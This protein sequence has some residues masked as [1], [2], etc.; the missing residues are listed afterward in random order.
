LAQEL[1]TEVAMALN[2]P[3]ARLH[4]ILTLCKK[5]EKESGGRPM[6]MGWRKVF[7]L[8]EGVRDFTVMQR[9]GR[10]HVLT[11]EISER[12]ERYPDLD[13]QLYLGWLEE[14]EEAFLNLS[15]RS[16][17]G[18]FV[19]RIPRTLLVNI[20]FCSKALAE[21]CPEP[22]PDA[23]KLAEIGRLSL[24]LIK[25]VSDSDLDEVGKRYFLDYLSLVRRA[26]EEYALLGAPGLQAVVDAVTGSLATQRQVSIPTRE[27]PVGKRFWGLIAK[28]TKALTAPDEE[29]PDADK[30]RRPG[31]RVVARE[32][33][34]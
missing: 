5:H 23:E 27:T 30:A 1:R 24:E 25:A 19:K 13:S 18:T 16:E 15:F 31:L 12:V 17:F 26:V 29:D 3:A 6:L 10:I 7:R 8:G 9:I 34:A 32:R 2:N 20:E 4:H 28:I 33:A 22:V 14:L 11:G 21:R